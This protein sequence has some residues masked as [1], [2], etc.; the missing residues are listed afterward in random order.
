MLEWLTGAS[1]SPHDIATDEDNNR[2]FAEEPPETPAP[3]FAVRALKSALFGTPVLEEDEEDDDIQK[4]TVQHVSPELFDRPLSPARAPVVSGTKFVAQKSKMD[5]LLSP[6]KGILLTPGTGTARRKT[7][8]FGALADF[9]KGL[10]KS[11]LSQEGESTDLTSENSPKLGRGLQ[12]NC[13]RETGL[14]RTLFEVQEKRSE[15]KL[16]EEGLLAED[17]SMTN[18]MYKTGDPGGKVTTDGPDV[19][20]DLKHPISRSGQ[21]WKK[22][23]QKDHDKS[24]KEMRKLIHYTQAAKSYAIKRDTEALSLSE[25]LKQALTRSAEMET[26]VSQLA[27]QLSFSAGQQNIIPSDQVELLGELATQTANSLRYKQKAEKYKMAI[28][29]QSTFT[30]GGKEMVQG[31]KS[32]AASGNLQVSVPQA[33]RKVDKLEAASILEGEEMLQLRNM[34]EL[35]E[36]KAAALI[37]ENLAL[38]NTLARVKQEMKA[39]E[40]RHQAREQRRKQKDERSEAQRLALQEELAKYRTMP[41]QKAENVPSRKSMGNIDGSRMK[42]LEAKALKQHTIIGNLNER[43]HQNTLPQQDENT[44]RQLPKILERRKLGSTTGESSLTKSWNGQD[45]KSSSLQGSVNIWA[46]YV[47]ELKSTSPR[48]TSLVYDES[49]LAELKHLMNEG[50][51]HRVRKEPSIAEKSEKKI[52]DS[53]ALEHVEK[54]AIP[55]RILP[56]LELRLA[57]APVTTL[58]SD[59]EEVL[60]QDQRVPEATS[61][62]SETAFQVR[63]QVRPQGPFPS[64]SRSNTLSRLLGNS[65]TNSLSGR[66]PLP[67]DR[68]EAARKRLEQRNV[69]MPKNGNEC[70]QRQF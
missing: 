12:E 17:Q 35:A 52:M 39:Y 61:K 23:Y 64:Q 53:K 4:P 45:M 62:S 67:P 19:T 50:H 51:G 68:A 37:K 33:R 25:K 48:D 1:R 55:A 9:D 43:Y 21:H 42:S 7:V 29:A 65:R 31:E 30:N 5:V 54:Y 6:A 32:N 18:P 66:P 38:K 57:P 40:I 70:E 2:S 59:Y 49:P 10:T 11:S 24:K 15:F 27:S 34:A 16:P 60:T 14:R 63:S 56:N 69:E 58:A 13:R 28:Q 3:L 41:Q 26:R 44:P 36:I 22:E 20:V 46:A 8:S 47:E